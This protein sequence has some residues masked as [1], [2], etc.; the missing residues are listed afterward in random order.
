M[1]GT[2]GIVNALRPFGESR[3]TVPLA[4]GVHA[5]PP[6]GQNLVRVALVTDIPDQTI[7]RRIERIMQGNR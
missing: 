1:G 7:I 3:K 5:L 4:K 6:A 2:E